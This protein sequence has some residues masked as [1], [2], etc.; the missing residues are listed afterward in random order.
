MSR[1]PAKPH[2]ATPEPSYLV[3]DLPEGIG[4]RDEPEP[5]VYTTTSPMPL[6]DPVTMS[7]TLIKGAPAQPAAPKA[8]VPA[9]PLLN[10]PLALPVSVVHQLVLA[11]LFVWRFE[12]LVADPVSTLQ[13]GL[14]V[15]A[16]IQTLYVTLC[17]PAAGSSGAKGSKKLRP[18]EKK[19]SDTREPKAF[20]TAVIS[21]VLAL[22]LTPV[23]H[24]LFVLFGAPFLT[25]A[26]HTF[27]CAAHIAVLAIYPIFYV[28]GSDPVPLQA[29]VSVSAPFDQTFGGF[30]GTVVG[31]WLG[32]VPIPLDWDREWQKWPVTIV[33]GAYVGYFVGS[34]LLGNV[35]Y[36]KRWAVSEI[37]EE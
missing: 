25:H 10:T 30:V 18:G 26:S 1:Q 33:A 5:L 2:L 15:V 35:F 12:A 20:A 6:I 14:P 13:I 22:I 7:T 21:L 9:I 23:L 36:G 27:L 19:K 29:V 31:A 16:V 37:K 24:I 3:G 28:R 11:G 17:L 4:D 8:V 32:A 34:K